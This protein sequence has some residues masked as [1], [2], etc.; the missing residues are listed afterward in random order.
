MHAAHKAGLGVVRHF[1]IYVSGKEVTL[2]DR[3]QVK[4]FFSEPFNLEMVP[5][6]E[7]W[8]DHNVK[9]YAWKKAIDEYLDS[10]CL[11]EATWKNLDLDWIKAAVSVFKRRDCPIVISQRVQILRQMVNPNNPE[12]NLFNL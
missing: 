11:S 10:G 6:R 1:L 3:E 12:E 7:N 8:S 4:Q 9:D 5:A 2:D